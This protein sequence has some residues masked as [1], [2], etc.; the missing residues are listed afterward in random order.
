MVYVW[1]GSGST[2]QERQAA[3]E[4]AQTLSTS[5]APVIELTQGEND[6]DEMFWVVL[7]D[8]DFAKADYW[9][10][11]R[12]SPLIDPRVWRVDSGHEHDSVSS[13][14]HFAHRCADILST[15]RYLWCT[16]FRMM[17][18]FKRQPTLSTASGNYS[19]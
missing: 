18:C 13:Y 16:R 2:S 19:F 7:G 9:Q 6:N 12:N 8:E 14:L 5:D 3:L 15:R 11:R 17:T 4:Y 10:W 1:Y